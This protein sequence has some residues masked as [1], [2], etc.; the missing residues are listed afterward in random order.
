MPH[1]SRESQG[2]HFYDGDRFKDDDIDARLNQADT[3]DEC[4]YLMNSHP[5]SNQE[6][7]SAFVTELNRLKA[8]LD[9][10]WKA[11][12]DDTVG[13]CRYAESGGRRESTL[14]GF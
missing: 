13:T 12:A 5:E 10:G 7:V 6:A 14:R 2:R 4:I 3:Y 8:R 9:G 11:S 1:L